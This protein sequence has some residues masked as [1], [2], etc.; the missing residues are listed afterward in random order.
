ME[1]TIIESMSRRPK[2]PTNQKHI[3]GIM[4]HATIYQWRERERE[5]EV[6]KTLQWNQCRGD[7]SSRRCRDQRRRS[8]R[9]RCRNRRGRTR[10]RIR[11]QSRSPTAQKG[12][13]SGWIAA[14]PKER[15][16]CNRLFSPPIPFSRSSAFLAG[17]NSVAAAADLV[18]SRQSV[19]AKITSVCWRPICSNQVDGLLKRV[20]YLHEYINLYIWV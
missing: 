15:I 5:I 8:Y 9:R 20:L 18:E 13:E 2:K 6:I 4:K 1:T 19:R 3:W 10:T 12:S 11:R 14:A 17:R 7:R 16:T